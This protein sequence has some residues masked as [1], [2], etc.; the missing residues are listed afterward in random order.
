MAVSLQRKNSI[1]ATKAGKAADSSNAS[2]G[3]RRSSRSRSR[4]S[5][6]SRRRSRSP[7][8]RS[9]CVV[10]FQQSHHLPPSVHPF[11]RLAYS[12]AGWL[13]APLLMTGS[14]PAVCLNRSRSRSR[15][16]RRSRSRSGSADRRSRKRRSSRSSSSSSRSSGR[17]RRR[18]SD[19][20]R[21]NVARGGSEREY[22]EP[23]RSSSLFSDPV[24]HPLVQF[25]D[26]MF[27]VLALSRQVKIAVP[28]RAPPF[29][30]PI[31]KAEVE[32]SLCLNSRSFCAEQVIK[33]EQTCTSRI[34]YA[35]LQCLSNSPRVQRGGAFRTILFACMAPFFSH[36]WI[37]IEGFGVEVAKRAGV[38]PPHSA[39]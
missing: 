7:R 17:R 25:T 9:R 6:R 20:G 19:S 27:H 2:T 21:G 38:G 13:R 37:R 4:S 11:T 1:D 32:P 5:S 18:R 33:H 8:R 10:A 35:E 31:T 14:C 29:K 26:T 24:S 30:E 3:S 36:D 12:R 39:S 28:K 34:S 15:S 22:W 23:V 16:R